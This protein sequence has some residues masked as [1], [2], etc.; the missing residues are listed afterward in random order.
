MT[1]RIEVYIREDLVD[2]AGE[3]LIKDIEDLNVKGAKSVRFVRVTEI[4]GGI[5]KGE[6]RRI[7]SELLS[8][9]VSQ[10]HV[11]GEVSG[12][13]VDGAWVIEVKFNKGVTDTV[14]DTTL[15]GI[16]DMGIA[17]ATGAKTSTKVVLRGK[18]SK[19]DVENIA[20]RLL[21]NSVIQSFSIAKS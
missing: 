15:K 3:G 9:P 12:P 10:R 17:G 14:A 5:S 16:A 4:E 2:A 13:V 6:A 11:I 7:A 8:D 1:T 21:A 19:S 20:R 18:I